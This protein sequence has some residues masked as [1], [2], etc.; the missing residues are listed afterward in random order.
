MIF[1]TNFILPAHI[2][3]NISLEEYMIRFL[4][5][6]IGT[7]CALLQTNG[8]E[9][10]NFI[11]DL[12]SCPNFSLKNYQIKWFKDDSILQKFVKENKQI[13]DFSLDPL[14]ED[15]Y[16]PTPI[17]LNNYFT[18]FINSARTDRSEA[19]KKGIALLIQQLY[20]TTTGT[21]ALFVRDPYLFS[22]PTKTTDEIK[23]LL[24]PPKKV[25]TTTGDL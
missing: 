4:Q 17:L 24:L 5:D 13:V 12:S 9:L 11:F 23:D 14:P 20:T 2:L 19:Q 7:S 25:I 18:F 6:P 1:F 21:E 16:T 3:A 10:N 22:M 8:K 15:I